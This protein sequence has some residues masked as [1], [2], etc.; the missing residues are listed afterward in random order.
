M[1]KRNSLGRRRAGVVFNYLCTL[2]LL[3]LFYSSSILGW[4]KW[5]VAAGMIVLISFVIVSFIIVH[6]KTGL[7]RLT[8]SRVEKLDERQVKVTLEA[9]RLSYTIFSIVCLVLILAAFVAADFGFTLIN[10]AVF[11][12]L[13]Y[14]AHTLPS[15]VLAWT[16]KEV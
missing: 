2:L 4:D 10:A 14:I 16:E 6:L 9:V 12:I 5:T 1:N 3:F 7:W 13:L 11:A 15:S 8:H